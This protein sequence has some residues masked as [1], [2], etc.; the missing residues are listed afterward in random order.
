M[1]I[2]YSVTVPESVAVVLLIAFAMFFAVWVLSVLELWQQRKR[3]NEMRDEI[4]SSNKRRIK[5]TPP[6]GKEL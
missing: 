4:N 6:Q 1:N 3:I 2:H 5:W